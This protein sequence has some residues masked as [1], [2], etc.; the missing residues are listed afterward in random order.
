MPL[1]LLKLCVGAESIQDLEE[2]IAQNLAG[3]AARGEPAEQFHTTRMVPTRTDELLDGGSLYWVIKGE[4]ACRQRLLA[5][6]PFVDGDGIR[7]CHLVLEPAVHKV[8]PRPSRPFQGWR[9]LAAKDAPADLGVEESSTV[10]P[11][12]LRRELRSLGLM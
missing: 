5:I 10:L 6:R 11:E 1:N 3:K 7:R 8:M 9:Y 2:W 12:H 4:V